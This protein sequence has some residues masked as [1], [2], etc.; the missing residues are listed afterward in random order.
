MLRLP[1]DKAEAFA[2]N[3]P[4]V[5]FSY[6][7]RYLHRLLPILALGL[8]GCVAVNT[9]DGTKLMTLNGFKRHATE[10]LVGSLRVAEEVTRGAVQFRAEKG[11]WPVTKD[12]ILVG[13]VRAGRE[14]EFAEEVATLELRW[15]E[16]D[17]LYSFR[18][19]SGPVWI[20]RLKLTDET[21]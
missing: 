8:S 10:N 9:G 20:I 1:F 18:M 4:P 3:S 2:Q 6:L 14:P 16:G 17:P 11:R 5:F 13:L 12:E 15:E 19:V 7:P 21:P